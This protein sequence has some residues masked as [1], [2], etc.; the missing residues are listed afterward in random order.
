[1]R[2]VA[3]AV[4]SVA[5]LAVPAAAEAAPERSVTTR[6]DDRRAVIVAA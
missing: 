3:A 6:L 2:W 4:L 5:S 1:M